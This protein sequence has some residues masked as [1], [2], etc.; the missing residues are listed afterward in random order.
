METQNLVISFDYSWFLAKNLAYDECWIMKFHYRNSSIC[1]AVLWFVMLT[2]F[3]IKEWLRIKCSRVYVHSE[4]II[5]CCWEQGGLL[6]RHFKLFLCYISFFRRWWLYYNFNFLSH[7][8]S[9]AI[10][11]TCLGLMSY[12]SFICVVQQHWH[13]LNAQVSVVSSMVIH[14]LVLCYFSLFVLY[15]STGIDQVHRC[16]LSNYRC[17][18]S[19][20]ISCIHLFL[21]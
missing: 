16:L 20:R 15:N 3:M 1:Y 6:A 19:S 21:D 14:T 9:I 10:A 17:H 7:P 11:D 2:Y 12:F 4:F 18:T 5:F 13:W 8:I